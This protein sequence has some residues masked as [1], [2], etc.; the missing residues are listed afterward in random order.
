MRDPIRTRP[1]KRAA[2]AFAVTMCVLALLQATPA[3]A[4]TFTVPK[5]IA[6]DCSRDVTR[7]LNRYFKS[8]PEGT[9]GNFTV[10]RFPARACYRINGTLRIQGRDWMTF[11]G[12]AT[13]PAVFRATR[14]GTLDFQGL[15]QRR[16]WWIINSDHIRIRNVRVQSTNTRPDPD[17]AGGGF[18]T[19]NTRYEF[20]H[21]FDI[22][23]GSDVWIT[24][25]EIRGVWG[26][27]IALN[28]AIGMRFGGA[29]T[30]G[31]RIMRV[32][33][34]WNGRQAIS[35][36][37]AQNILFDG[38]RIINSRRAGFDLEPNTTNNVVRDI[39]IRNSYTNTHLLAFASAGRSEVSDIYI[40][41]NTIDASG[42][43]IVYVAAS[44]QSRRYDWR[45]SNNV[46]LHP[47]GSPAPALLFRYVTNVT[48]AGNRIP[49][50]TTQSRTA[51]GFLEA[52][53]ALRVTN[54]NFL[55][56]GCYITAID[57]D[58]VDAHD[59]QLGCP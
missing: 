8:V 26:D 56:G 15:S 35:L 36:V 50:V 51:V 1:V 3:A 28:H 55:S 6:R 18:A 49:V 33:C 44:D 32:R 57:S 30:V 42:I 43:P 37:D 25:T 19:Y 22:S 27:C 5:R 4:G 7:D 31:D 54:N 16:H 41:D 58:P 10:V 39:E 53:G 48:V 23:G 13:A 21:G 47:A 20:E 11:T 34:A 29:G 45:F 40:H 52:Y 17:I 14:R 24:D 2:A 59:N 38:V 9:S 12:S 46:L